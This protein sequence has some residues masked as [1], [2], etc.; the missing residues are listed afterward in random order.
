MKTR[1][2]LTSKGDSRAVTVAC[3]IVYMAAYITRNTYPAAI[4]HLTGAGLLSQSEAGLISSGY[5]IT[6]GVGHLINGFLADRISPS[7]ML[8]VGICGTVAANVAMIFV[9]PSVPFMAAVWWLNGWFES[10]L[11]APIVALLSSMIAPSMRIKAMKAISSSRCAGMITAYLLTAVS[12]Y[13]DF[14][15]ITPYII[16]AS[17]AAL[18]C[19]LLAVVVKRAF[20]SPTVVDAVFEKKSERG[21]ASVFN[22]LFI[23][24]ALV[25]AVP[26]V[27]HGMLKEGVKTW[28]P[29]F[30]HDS[31]ST[32]EALS[33]LLAVAIPAA[34]LF[35]VF[36]ANLLL[37]IKPLHKNH[38][39]I[40][41]ILMLL[42]GVPT[43][44]LFLA[45]RMPLAVGV[46]CLCLIS[47]LMEAFCHI[48]SVMMPAEFAKFGKASTVSGIFNSLIY[49]G[50]AVSIYAF[51]AVAE[52]VGWSFTVIIWTAL[53]LVSALILIFG[54]RTWG[55]FIKPKNN[56]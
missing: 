13:C 56:N 33:T 29:S 45:D 1:K 18:T 55:R 28:V 38:S 35:G 34:G 47:L 51:G 36:F 20:S 11:W 49:I 40:G 37:D 15:I 32:T 24:G 50:S 19:V 30:L 23:S 14:G 9:T 12:A 17:C 46:I 27:F 2:A 44:L 8:T 41:I 10:M 26:S 52:N 43:A 48:F 42:T 53:A 6:Y 3:W 39:V 22:L 21:G 7:K 5:F 54:I 16:A 4:V 31:F 25:F